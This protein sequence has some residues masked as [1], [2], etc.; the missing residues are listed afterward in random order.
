MLNYIL[1]VFFILGVV[2]FSVFSFFTPLN[3]LPIYINNFIS[4]IFFVSSLFYFKN[5]LS[6]FNSRKR[7]FFFTFYFSSFFVILNNII[8]FFYDGDFF[9]FSKVDALQYDYYGRLFAENLSFNFIK[10]YL[11][12]ESIDDLGAVIYVGIIYTFIDSNLLVNFINLIIGA[13]SSV[14]IFNIASYFINNKYAFY[15]AVAYSCSSYVI[16]FHSSGLKESVM[17]LLIL[18]FFDFYYKYLKSKNIIYFLLTILSGLSMLFFRIPLVGILYAS[19]GISVLVSTRVNLFNKIFFFAIILFIVTYSTII[20]SSYNRFIGEDIQSMLVSK[21]NTG[22]VF[23][24]YY[25]SYAMNTLGQL[26]GP[27]PTFIPINNK[28]I[29][30]FYA[31]GLLF[32]VLIAPLFFIGAFHAISIKKVELYPLITFVLFEM[33]LLIFILEGLEL[34]KAVLHMPLIYVISFWAIS[35]PNLIRDKLTKYK[36]YIVIITFILIIWNFRFG[37]L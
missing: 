37:A 12:L 16:W 22:M 33:F 20:E 30:S 17:S 14:L 5:N 28:I 32:R 9:V 21:E 19:I 31:P 26:L 2:L 36:I 15:T 1:T 27:F 11:L 10:Y 25:I 8:S 13:F 34:R 6:P 3:F 29:L 35:K 23:D 24:N 4:F 7:L 18:I